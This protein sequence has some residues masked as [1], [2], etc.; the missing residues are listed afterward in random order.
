[1]KLTAVAIAAL[2]AAISFAGQN[3]AFITK[4]D[5]AKLVPEK[6]VSSLTLRPES[7][8]KTV[9]YR[10]T[11][12]VKLKQPDDMVSEEE[13]AITPA[14]SKRSVFTFISILLL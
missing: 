9:F 11:M 2:S 4:P 6:A 12:Q 10:I 5:K 13:P 8:D 1:M 7:H 14:A 3:A